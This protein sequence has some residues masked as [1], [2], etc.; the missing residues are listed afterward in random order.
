MCW[1]FQNAFSRC[2]QHISNKKNHL[3]YEPHWKL[4]WKPCQKFQGMLKTMSK[5]QSMSK[6]TMTWPLCDP[7]HQFWNILTVIKIKSDIIYEDYRSLWCYMSSLIEM[8]WVL[9]GKI[10][11]VCWQLLHD[12]HAMENSFFNLAVNFLYFLSNWVNLL[13]IFSGIRKL[14]AY[15]RNPCF[16]NRY[17]MP[18][19]WIIKLLWECWNFSAANM[20]G[21]RTQCKLQTMI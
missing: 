12:L 8:L 4:C 3:C 19:R 6:I 21:N 15:E 10:G 9:A 18:W 7:F 5:F 16:W 11:F 20:A 14:R 1:N 13:G 17:L 2:F